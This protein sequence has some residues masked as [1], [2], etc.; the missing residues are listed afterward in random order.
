MLGK[1]YAIARRL[2]GIFVEHMP[3]LGMWKW[4]DE[5]I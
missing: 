3:S 1:K 4:Y 2:G 5:S